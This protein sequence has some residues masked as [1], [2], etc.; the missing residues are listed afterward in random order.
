ME[1]VENLSRMPSGV[2][3]VCLGSTGSLWP[4]AAAVD[5]SMHPTAVS[6]Q[7]PMGAEKSAHHTRHAQGEQA[8][9][10]GDGMV[11]EALMRNEEAAWNDVRGGWLGNQRVRGARME[12]VGVIP[13]E[14][15]D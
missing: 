11:I 13:K 4:L 5:L 9:S 3:R 12:E 15:T 14:G 2:S 8:W 10:G 6:G 7:T 1:A